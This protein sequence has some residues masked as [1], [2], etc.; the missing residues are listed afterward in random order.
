[1]VN[2]LNFCTYTYITC[3]YDVHMIAQHHGAEE[4][5]RAHNPEV[6]GSKPIGANFL[7]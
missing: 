2:G 3:F 5:R 7:P 1:M 6:I 4:A